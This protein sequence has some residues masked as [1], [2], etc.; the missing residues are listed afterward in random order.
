MATALPQLRE[1]QAAICAS[2]LH[3]TACRDRDGGRE[4]RR[5]TTEAF[6]L[7]GD[8]LEGECWAG[9]RWG[10]RPAT[11]I[12]EII[13]NWRT[14]L[15]TEGIRGLGDVVWWMLE[16]LGVH[17]AESRWA[18]ARSAVRAIATGGR[19]LLWPETTPAGCGCQSR[20]AWLN[21]WFPVP[22]G[23]RCDQRGGQSDGFR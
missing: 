16:L 13:A 5:T 14:R 9:K 23:K 7:A 1:F 3:C 11:P 6:G 15:R 18:W 2:G 8:A 20:R 19:S 12:G 10:H 22:W 21:R 4:F 17:A